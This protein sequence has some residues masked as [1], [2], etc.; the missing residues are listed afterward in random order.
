MCHRDEVNRNILQAEFSTNTHTHTHTDTHTHRR[1]DLKLFLCSS[2]LYVHVTHVYITVLTA[3][4]HRV[5]SDQQ[6]HKR[7]QTDSQP[8]RHDITDPPS[9]LRH[10]EQ[11][12]RK[13]SEPRTDH[14]NCDAPEELP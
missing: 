14:L 8:Q 2:P 12:H 11:I 10:S 4:T 13:E 7:V 5:T 1:N 6:T 9:A 3:E